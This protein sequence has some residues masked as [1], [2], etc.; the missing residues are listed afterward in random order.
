MSS[1]YLTLYRVSVKTP[2]IMLCP[3][4]TVI[5]LHFVKHVRYT[6]LLLK[7]FFNSSA[8]AKPVV[9][10]LLFLTVSNSILA[11]LALFRACSNSALVS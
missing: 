9:T 1:E 6:L 4:L 2:Y 11:F 7:L 3:F 10:D 5:L 8:D